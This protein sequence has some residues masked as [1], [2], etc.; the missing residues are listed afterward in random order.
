MSVSLAG[1]QARPNMASNVAQMQGRSGNSAQD[2]YQTGWWSRI[3]GGATEKASAIAMSNVDRAFQ[4]EQAKM[5]REFQERL[6]S[7]AYQR[8]MTDMQKAGLNPALMYKGMSGAS[9]PGGATASGSRTTP[10][11]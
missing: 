6:S 3:T 5:N 1:T 7:S 2:Q 8:A 10:P 4:A 11:A 9:T